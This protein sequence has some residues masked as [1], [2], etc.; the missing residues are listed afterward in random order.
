MS[1][2]ETQADIPPIIAKYFRSA[3]RGADAEAS[4]ARQRE[5]C[6]KYIAQ[7][8]GLSEK[9]SHVS[10]YTDIGSGK[11]DD[12]PGMSKL[13]ADAEA[14]KFTDLVV[15]DMSRLSRSMKSWVN[16]VTKL[17]DTAVTIHFVR[18]NISTD[19]AVTRAIL[20]VLIAFADLEAPNPA[21]AT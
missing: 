14:G 16:L 18:N 11:R 17:Q 4:L 1:C 2:V 13:L 20:A 15:E 12:L 10:E 7:R 19:N 3:V 6:S 21:R 8:F 9:D 5:G